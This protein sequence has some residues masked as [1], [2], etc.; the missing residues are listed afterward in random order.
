MQWLRRFIARLALSRSDAALVRATGGTPRTVRGMTLDARFQ[1]IEDQSRKRP[2]DWATVTPQQL[3]PPF[4]QMTATFS[5]PPV[6]GVR[7]EKVYVTGRSHSV[8]C[9][10]YL[11]Q[12]RN[13]S[14]AMLVYFHQGGG[15]IGS[16]ESCHRLCGLI[17]KHA[18]APVLSVDYRLAPEHRYPAGLDDARAAYVWALD[19]AARYGVPARKVGVGGDSMGGN[20]AALLAL[21]ARDGRLAQ[22]ALQLLI[23]PAVDGV[24][25]TASMHEFAD[26]FPLTDD[27]LQYFLRQYV[28]EGEDLADAKISPLRA[29]SLK[30]LA[31]ALCY[32]AGFDMLLDQGEAYAD[33]MAEEGVR[34]A[35]ARFDS[36]PHGFVSFPGAAPAAEAAIQRI[37]Q[38]TALALK[39]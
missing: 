18:G 1:F 9:R 20:F 2:V 33:R 36:L 31:P 11:P 38:E 32:N 29:P 34:V 25:D 10:V 19:N 37:A 28:H 30:G 23:Y 13:N 22:P 39:G 35:R 3:R 12:V 4:E 24:S 5:G 14:T 16:L 15:V 7:V 8:P 27:L 26:A 17:A 21:E 6:S